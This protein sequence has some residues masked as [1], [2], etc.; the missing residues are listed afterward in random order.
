MSN[1][2]MLFGDK[3]SGILPVFDSR[4][5]QHFWRFFGDKNSRNL[6][7]LE[8]KIPAFSP[9]LAVKKFRHFCRFVAENSTILSVLVAKISTFL[10]FF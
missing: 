5:F 8:S 10:H 6:K 3:N 4:K 7:F 9:F 1:F 2:E